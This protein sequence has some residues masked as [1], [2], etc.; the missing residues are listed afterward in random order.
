VMIVVAWLFVRTPPRRVDKGFRRLQ[1][2][3]AGIYNLGHGANNA[4][5]CMGMLWL[6]LLASGAMKMGDAPPAW[7][8]VGSYSVIALGTLLGGWR[9]V[10]SMGQKITKLKPDGGFCAEAGGALTLMLA[11]NLGVPISPRQA[12][13]G[14][15][16]GIGASRRMTV[17]RWSV[18]TNMALAWLLTIPASAFFGASVWWLAHRFI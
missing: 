2:L 10:K 7:A 18:V 8:V 5:K 9:V 12:I 6:L 4:Q 1:L 11:N 17:V 15:L 3:S 14:A 16:V 13:T